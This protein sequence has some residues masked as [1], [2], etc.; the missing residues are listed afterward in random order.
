MSDE[1]LEDL[2]KR[3]DEIDD[4]L[5]DLVSQRI[6]LAGDILEKK[7]KA[8]KKIRDPGREQRVLEKVRE[9][10]KGE[11]L[12]PEFVESLTRLIISETAGRQE[13]MA[14]E[15]G[16]WSQIQE[17]FVGN[18]AQLKVARTLFKYGLKVRENGDIACGGIRVPD[19]QIA[20]EAGVDRRAIGSTAETILEDD[21]LRGIFGNLRPIPYLKGVAQELGLGVMDIF[22]ADATKSGIISEVSKV[23][24][25]SGESIRQTIADDPKFVAEPKLTIITGDPVGGEVIEK[26]RELP[27][28]ESIVVY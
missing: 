28:V 17:R 27:S 18:P 20:E 21:K 19:V 5:V 3:I 14:G 22:A 24:S 25:E 6:D 10:A 12:D 13:E 8:G 7:E 1:K 23:I 15:P 26:L 11:D 16:M 4:Q 2:R 9:K